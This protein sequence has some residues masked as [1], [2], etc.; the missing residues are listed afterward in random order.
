VRTA[1]ETVGRSRRSGALLIG[2]T[3]LGTG[4][5]AVTPPGAGPRIAADGCAVAGD[6]GGQV[7]CE[8]VLDNSLNNISIVL[9]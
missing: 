2:A 7:H 1:T 4:L 5:A 8:N 6:A 9:G 3:M